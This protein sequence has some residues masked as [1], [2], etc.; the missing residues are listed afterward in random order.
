M[1]IPQ[2]IK[3]AEEIVSKGPGGISTEW[4]NTIKKELEKSGRNK[5]VSGNAKALKNTSEQLIQK[6]E[7]E[8][9]KRSIQITYPIID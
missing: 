2:V 9:A 5:I 3:F 4:A 7:Q 6:L 8:Y 1:G